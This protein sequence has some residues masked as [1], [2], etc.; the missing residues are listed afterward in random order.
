[1]KVK[2]SVSKTIDSSNNDVEPLVEESTFV[3]LLRRKKELDLEGYKDEISARRWLVDATFIVTVAWLIC[4]ICIFCKF[5][6]GKYYFSDAVMITFLT[7][8]TANTLAF[9]TIIF[10]YLFSRNGQTE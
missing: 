6:S 2:A 4:V 9:L 1:M 10:R 7:T 8:T 3:E 5:G